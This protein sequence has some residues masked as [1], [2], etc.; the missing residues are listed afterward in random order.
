MCVWR[1]LS[2][3]VSVLLFGCGI[4]EVVR[5]Y[6]G[7]IFTFAFSSIFVFLALVAWKE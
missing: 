5:N 1:A 2:L 4:A 3:A 6:E 7:T